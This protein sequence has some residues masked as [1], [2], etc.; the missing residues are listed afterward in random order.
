MAQLKDTTI[1][2]TLNVS[3]FVNFNQMPTVNGSPIVK[4]QQFSGFVATKTFYR[5]DPNSGPATT[6]VFSQNPLSTSPQLVNMS[7]VIPSFLRG[8]IG[9]IEVNIEYYRLQSS[10]SIF[11]TKPRGAPGSG[12]DWRRFGVLWGTGMERHKEPYTVLTDLNGDFEIWAYTS[13]W[14]PRIGR[15]TLRGIWLRA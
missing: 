14:T 3:D 8:D 11:M 2:G 6:N 12:N 13:S 4:R 5:M 10:G 15:I 7:S 1:D 9:A